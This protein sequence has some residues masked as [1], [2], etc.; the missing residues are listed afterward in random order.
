MILVRTYPSQSDG[1]VLLS[2]PSPDRCWYANSPSIA[3]CN[4][5]ELSECSDLEVDTPALCFKFLFKSR[6]CPRDTLA[7]PFCR[8]PLS[9]LVSFTGTNERDVCQTEAADASLTRRPYKAVTE[10]SLTC[11]FT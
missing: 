7:V 6:R 9:V 5:T 2:G 3:C 8:C 1:P 4:V 11:G 10:S